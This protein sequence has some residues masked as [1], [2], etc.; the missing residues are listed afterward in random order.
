M[1]GTVANS[2]AA[3]NTTAVSTNTSTSEASQFSFI[4]PYDQTQACDI[5][6]ALCQ[7]GSITVGVNLTSKT[8]TTVLPCSSYLSAQSSFLGN[9]DM[10]NLTGNIWP[11][12]WQINFGRSPECR[13]YA[14]A[15]S[16]G[17]Y[18]ASNCGSGNSS[19]YT[20]ASAYLES[21]PVQMPPGVNRYES[22][23]K[24]YACCGNCSLEI[25]EVRL[26]YFPDDT[27]TNCHNNQPFNSTSVLSTG[28][29]GKR[30][31][32]LVGDGGIAVVSGHTLYARPSVSPLVKLTLSVVLPHLSTFK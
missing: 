31:Q 16:R 4:I 5:Y 11:M 28:T 24:I 18:T 15:F 1:N 7:T 27:A 9:I 22:P 3:N 29:L 12:E 25:P 6:G 2:T 32:S 30:M 8:S 14:R 17:Q 19:V 23:G 10:G 26:Y 20:V 21:Y 13:S